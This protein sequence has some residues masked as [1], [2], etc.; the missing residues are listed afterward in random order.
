MEELDNANLIPL[1]DREKSRGS[2]L[3][4]IKRGIRLDNKGKEALADLDTHERDL[5]KKLA[6]VQHKHDDINGTRKQKYSDD[7][8]IDDGDMKP[9]SKP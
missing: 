9:A 8:S 6:I 7:N 5:L 4:N 1:H 2:V 3:A